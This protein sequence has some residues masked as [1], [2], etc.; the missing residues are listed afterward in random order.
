M[1]V[2]RQFLGAL[3]GAVASLAQEPPAASA[4]PPEKPILVYAGKPLAVAFQCADDDMQWAG[5]SC[6]R[7]EPCPVYLELSSLEVAGSSLF[8]SG[9]LHSAATTLYSIVLASSDGGKTWT[10]PHERIRGAGLDQ[11][12]FIDFE[13]GWIAGQVLHPLPQDPFLL[14][15]KD[16]GK[17]WRRQSIF[18]ETRYGSVAQFWFTSKND[19]SI[20]VDR[21]QASDTSRYEKYESPNGGDTWMIRETNDQAPRLR[22]SP[23]NTDWRIRADGPTQSFRIERRQGNNW[24]AVAGFLIRAGE[25]KPPEQKLAEPPQEPTEAAPEQQPAPETPSTPAAP[26]RRPTLKRK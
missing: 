21:G 8:L 23:P 9:N 7:E 3:I 15:T 5:M 6:S 25:C 13:S 12:Q 18:S 10:E 14:A 4:P 24:T 17:T 22:R 20:V 16:G 19:G 1:A 11:I 26:R 2:R